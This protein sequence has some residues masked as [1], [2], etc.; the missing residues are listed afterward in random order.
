METSGASTS[1]CLTIILLMHCVLRAQF[2]EIFSFIALYDRAKLV[3]FCCLSDLELDVVP[4]MKSLL[5]LLLPSCRL[6]SLCR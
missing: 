3:P 1:N 5:S 4:S 6:P 2:K